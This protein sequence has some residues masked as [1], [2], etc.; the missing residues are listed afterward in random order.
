MPDNYRVRLLALVAMLVLSAGWSGTASAQASDKLQVSARLGVG[1]APTY[2]GSNDY[3]AVP[4]W[5]LR[6]DNLYAPDTYV[7]L[8]NTTLTSNLLPNT[9]FRLGP[10]V[11][12]IPTRDNVSDSAVN[13]FKHVDASLMLGGLIGY[14]FKL[15]DRQVIGVEFQGRQDV[16][17]SNG[18]LLTL[19]GR[20][21]TPLPAG[22]YFTGELSSTYASSDYMESYF[23]VSAANAARS[24]L[25][26]FNADSGIKDA[27]LSLNLDYALF[28]AVSLGFAASYSRLFND[29]KDSPIVSDRGD[30]NQF[31]AGTTLGYRF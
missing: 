11:Q 18:Y 8:A 13:D 3:Q 26:Q 16:E 14:D 10:M 30:E 27:K 7:K 9:N 24:G 22:L 20:Y 17:S 19:L 6:A 23:G 15:S 1:V 21:Q 5:L 4:L 25:D 28:D 2:E 31:F 29:A 12:Y